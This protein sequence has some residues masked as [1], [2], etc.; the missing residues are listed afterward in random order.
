MGIGTDRLFML[1]HNLVDE[2]SGGSCAK[3]GFR[4][5]H[6]ID[7]RMHLVGYDDARGF[8]N[9]DEIKGDDYV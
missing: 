6:E 7:N 8:I 4:A 2:S 9:I 5:E 1:S 3:M